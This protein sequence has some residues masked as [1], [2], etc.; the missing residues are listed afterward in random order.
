MAYNWNEESNKAGGKFAD[1][2][3]EGMHNLKII[4]VKQANKDGQ[5]FKDKDGNDSLGIVF[6]DEQAREAMVFYSLA[7]QYTYIFA[8]L[9][10]GCG[11]NLDKLQAAGIEPSK[12]AEEKYANNLIDKTLRG[13]V[14]HTKG[15]NGKTFTSIYPE[16]PQGGASRKAAP[17]PEPDLSDAFDP[18]ADLTDDD[19]K[20]L[21][22][23][24]QDV[25]VF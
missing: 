22:P 19:R 17:A 7:G 14:K 21:V 8:K 5:V 10:K 2:I 16:I 25:P 23:S 20:A 11:V 4:K 6:A 9:L 24:S 13:E 18:E 1:L 12:F 3:P 15:N